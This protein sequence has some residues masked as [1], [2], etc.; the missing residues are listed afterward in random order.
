MHPLI[1][2]NK[3]AITELCKK[4]H[5]RKLYLFGSALNGNFSEQSD[6]DFFYE[7]DHSVFES[8]RNGKDY[9][10]NIFEFGEGLKNVLKRNVDLIRHDLHYPSLF[11]EAVADKKALIYAQ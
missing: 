1:E 3:E 8:Q 4:Y 9:A 10:A 2:T 5:V 7:M 11:I 6:V